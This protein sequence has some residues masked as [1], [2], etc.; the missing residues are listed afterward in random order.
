MKNSKVI[1]IFAA[2]GFVLSFVFALMSHSSILL[3][4]LKAL[5]TC[6]SFGVLGLL[7]SFVFNKFL[8]EDIGPENI[9]ESDVEK[10]QSASQGKGQIVD[11]VISDEEL[12]K[13]ESGNHFIVSSSQMLNS[14]DVSSNNSQLFE[15]KLET[16]DI[17]DPKEKF[18]P[19]KEME[20]VTNFS[21]KESEV[22]RNVIANNIT[23]SD[24]DVDTLPDMSNISLV[25]EDKAENNEEEVSFTSDSDT[26]FSTTTAKSTNTE[27]QGDTSNTELIAKAISSVLSAEKD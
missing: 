15:N 11:L 22:S 10:N 14:T 2:I 23:E 8:S 20:T 27:F 7:I 16:S 5:I 18:V 25:N 21:S 19:L 13:G 1:V 24:G 6:V 4:L 17:S 3:V 12:Q 26:V 9:S